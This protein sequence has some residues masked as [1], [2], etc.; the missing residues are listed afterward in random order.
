LS[1]FSAERLRLSSRLFLKIL[2]MFFGIFEKLQNQ[3][4]DIINKKRNLCFRKTKR[5]RIH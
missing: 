4:Q 2:E 1:S 5:I 3:Y